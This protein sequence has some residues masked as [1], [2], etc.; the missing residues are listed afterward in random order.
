MKLGEMPEAFPLAPCYARQGI[1]HYS[2]RDYMTFYRTEADRVVIIRV[3]HG[4]RDY[5][6]LLFHER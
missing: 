5:E 6:A 2:H 4:A 3:L 1:H